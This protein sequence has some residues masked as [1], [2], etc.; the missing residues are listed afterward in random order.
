MENQLDQE[1]FET[2]P[3]LVQPLVILLVDP[4]DL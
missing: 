4:M 1:A 2:I 3:R